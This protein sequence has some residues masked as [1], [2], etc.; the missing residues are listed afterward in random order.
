MEHRWFYIVV[1]AAFVITGRKF[2][3]AW[4]SE[5]ADAPRWRAIH[6]TACIGCFLI[7]AFFEIQL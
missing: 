1:L 6:L 3:D 4:K 7:V 5:A 2:L